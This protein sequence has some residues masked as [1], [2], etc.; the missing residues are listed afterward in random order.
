MI[1]YSDGPHPLQFITVIW[2][3]RPQPAKVLANKKNIH[4]WDAPRRPAGSQ[5]DGTQSSSSRTQQN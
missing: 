3:S 1:I 5:I 4:A 2:N